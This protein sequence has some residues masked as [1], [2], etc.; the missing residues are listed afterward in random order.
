MEHS[1]LATMAKLENKHWWYLGRRIII[2]KLLIRGIRSELSTEVL[3]I[4]AGTGGNFEMLSNFGKYTGIEPSEF[5]LNLMKKE[6]R[7]SVEKKSIEDLHIDQKK[8][9]LIALF[10]VLEHIR[11]DTWAL[12]RIYEKLSN[13]GRL[14]ITVP[15]YQF[16]WS[17]HDE[18]HHHFRRYTKNNLEKKIKDAGFTV[19]ESSYFN[20]IL[21]PVALV[22]RIVS[23]LFESV[24]SIGGG[25]VNPFLNRLFINILRVEAKLMAL[26]PLPFGLSIIVLCRK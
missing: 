21:F 22:L 10:D 2:E 26:F 7:E 14:I 5:A 18:V 19:I 17:K 3:E 25:E 9:D 8:Y 1:E 11:D 6:A 12:N 16:L 13:G 20:F 15:A 23:K 24:A 4:G